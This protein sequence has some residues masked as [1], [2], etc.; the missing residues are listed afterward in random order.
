MNQPL[1]QV[2]LPVLSNVLGN[3]TVAGILAVVNLA[4]NTITATT[5]VLNKHGRNSYESYAS[6]LKNQGYEDYTGQNAYRGQ[7]EQH[8]QGTPFQSLVMNTLATAFSSINTAF[9]SV[10]HS[11][12][13]LTTYILVAVLSYVAFKITY[14]VVS[15]VVRSV[16][17][18]I[19]L[20]I[21][22]TIVTSIVWFIINITSASR[23]SDSNTGRQ[24]R[25]QDPISQLLYS[26]Q[27]KFQAEF[28]RQQQ[29]LQDPYV[30]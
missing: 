27:N 28:E 17:N 1:L 3:N 2:T 16:L 29:Y 5:A 25:H 19:K 13:P 26:L 7:G 14:A 12:T 18:L 6:S 4:L 8:A 23:G 30:Y 9:A 11:E 15:W 10:T 22:V 24:H 20:T 21:I